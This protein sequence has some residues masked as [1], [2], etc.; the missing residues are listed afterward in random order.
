MLDPAD[1]NAFRKQSHLILDQTLDYLEGVRERATW[2][3]VPQGVRERLKSLLPIEPSEFGD[4]YNEFV[5]DI[6]PYNSGNIHPRFF[7]WVQ[8]TGTPVGAIADL[9]AAAMNSNCGGRD[10]GAIY[11]ER[12]V[13]EWFKE[14][15]EFPSTAA[16]LLVT[17]TSMAN[18]IAVLVARTSALG[19][20]VR[21]QGLHAQSERLVGYASAST[22]GCVRKAFENAG[23]GAA[24][25]RVL[26]VDRTHRVNPAAILEAIRTDRVAGLRPFMIVG[27]AGSVDIGAID[28]LD[29]LADL[30]ERENLWLHVDGAFGA[31]TMLCEQL[32]PALRGIERA[33][34]LAFD[35]H[36]WLHVP[37]D[38]GC[39]LVRDEAVHRATFSTDGRYITRMDRG[40][41]AG[42]P[43]FTDFGPD[44]SRGFRAL[45]V[46]FTIKLHGKKRLA[47]SIER[48]CAQAHYLKS[49]IEEAP[50]FELMAPVTLNI[51]CF[52]YLAADLN[53]AGLDCFNDNLVIAL[54]ESGVA[55]ASSTT[56]GERRAIRVCIV[57]HRTEERDLD[58][59]L[60]TLGELAAQ[61]ER[62]QS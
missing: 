11:V 23:L 61:L 58:L 56:I 7:G 40:L 24:S 30:A 42:E 31:L 41:A 28:P 25:L 19:P 18:L 9:L 16:G 21:D 48:N 37:Y 43:W 8:G 39:V 2:T 15:F 17:G 14:L 1:W 26:P 62:R 46:W 12:A 38:A 51:V 4:V 13:I 29:E 20:A 10:H 5:R 27:N 57:N 35:L 6:L 33:D 44:L 32:R 59:L 53:P 50:R 55:V 47:E 60:Q 52:R 22:H 3:P 54:Q 34:S 45:K 49:L 36:K